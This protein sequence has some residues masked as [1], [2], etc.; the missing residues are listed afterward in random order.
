MSNSMT[1]SVSHIS[2]ST[3]HAIE[4]H[5]KLRVYLNHIPRLQQIIVILLFSYISIVI[6]VVITFNPEFRTSINPVE[7]SIFST[8]LLMSPIIFL[9]LSFAN[10][11]FLTDYRLTRNTVVELEEEIKKDEENHGKLINRIDFKETLR[12][13][14]VNFLQLQYIIGAF[15]S[16]ALWFMTGIESL[17]PLSLIY[18]SGTAIFAYYQ[19]SKNIPEPLAYITSTF[20]KPSSLTDQT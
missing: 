6:P 11:A 13:K 4:A 14:F 12:Y 2:E 19:S 15:L 18:G 3:K 16:T 8:I 1:N 9:I 7:L 20:K 5:N 10:I 17:E